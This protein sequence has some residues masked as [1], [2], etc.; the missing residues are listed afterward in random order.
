M[1]SMKGGIL[2]SVMVLALLV[3]AA[4]SFSSISN[5]SSKHPLLDKI[6]QN[7]TMID[8]KYG[9][10]PLRTGDSAY[11]ENKE[12]IT[13]CLANPETNEEYDLNTLTYVALHE[14]GHVVSK[15]T[16]HGPE[17]K[18]NFSK[19]LKKGAELGIYDPRKPI[20]ANYCNVKVR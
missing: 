12:V 10:I 2:I 17:F 3:T 15:S 11:T 18:E 1:N 20:P 19:L 14:L 13:L 16:G 4:Y 8:P 6:R 5:Y 9:K 7:F